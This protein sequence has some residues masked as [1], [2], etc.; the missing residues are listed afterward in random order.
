MTFNKNSQ[1][2]GVFFTPE[3]QQRL[4]LITHL[5]PNSRQPILLR[6]PAESGK[7]FFLREF[8]K[9]APNNWLICMLEA[10]EMTL[11]PTDAFESSFD[12]LE[13]SDKPIRSRLTAW[14]RIEK[15]VVVLV[16]DMHLLDATGIDEL[17]RLSEEHGCL[18]LLMTSS[19]NLGEEVEGH[20]QLID[21]EPFSQKQTADYAKARIN[22][23]GIDFVN[24]AGI[25]DVV[26]FIETGGL[27][28][29]INDVLQQMQ[30]SPLKAKAVK[31]GSNT[32][33]ILSAVVISLL[34]AVLL[35]QG[36]WFDEVVE[37]ESTLALPKEVKKIPSL[38]LNRDVL[39][40][41]PAPVQI[42]IEKFDKSPL[43]EKEVKADIRVEPD[44]V[45]EEEMAL[46][47]P[48]IEIIKAKKNKVLEKV[49]TVKKVIQT[50]VV[51]NEPLGLNHNWLNAQSTSKFTLQLLGVSQESSAKK[52]LASKKGVQGL[53]YFRN[54]KNDG[55]WFTVIYGVYTDKASAEAA[56]KILPKELKGV[57][58][59]LR[60][61][62]DV[63]S[64]MYNIK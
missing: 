6:G 43:Q 42:P 41:K 21:L 37:P 38:A 18:R 58:P 52:Y 61:I 17:F 53:H 39:I 35:T 3:R 15:I 4:D 28:G 30:E 16:E 45:S 10:D 7:S 13:N 36:F 60:S 64:D 47:E 55:A 59:W 8:K 11:S 62:Q 50:K 25:D 27:P 26:L 9:Q 63:Q 2:Q 20:C 14:S 54:K 24:L 48:L 33:F 1:S 49:P 19:E 31:K 56:A 23:K 12:Q 46:K 57:S 29:R 44:Q 51:R 5:I 34:I 40:K 22:A 32:L